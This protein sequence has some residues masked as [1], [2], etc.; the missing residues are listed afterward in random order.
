MLKLKVLGGARKV[1]RSALLVEAN[2]FKILLDYGVD[3]SGKEPEF[4]LHVRPKDVAATLITHAHLDHSGAAPLLY[5]S[6]QPKLI[7]TQLTLALTDLLVNDFLKL[8]KYYVPYDTGDLEK[9]KENALLLELEETLE[10]GGISIRFWNAGHIPGSVMVDLETDTCRL[11]YTGDF[12]IVDTHLLSGASIEPFKNADT[13]IME[14]TYAGF[15]HPPREAAEREFVERVIEVLDSGGKVLIPAFAVARSQEILCM[16]TKH[17]IKYPIY[18]DGMARRV[19]TILLENAHGLRD[20]DL[21]RKACKNA[22]H[23][24][25]PKDR[26]KALQI[27]SVI[28]SPAAMLKGGA[29]VQYMKHVLEDPNSGVFFVSY[30]MHETPARRILETGFFNHDTINKKVK[31]RLEWFDFSSHCGRSELRKVV[32]SLDSRTKLILVHSDS[33][34]GQRFAE[35]VRENFDLDVVYPQEGEVLNIR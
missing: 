31:A 12:N 21:Y 34:I 35:W 26:K 7:A 6:S 23:V 11:L 10:E 22:H 28:I 20:P 13:V 14:A 3:I 18:V 19:N 29:S 4:P 9:M 32:E 1:G 16:L 27:P 8:S 24:T 2:N 17:G 25:S 5:V 33:Q 30:L 15:D